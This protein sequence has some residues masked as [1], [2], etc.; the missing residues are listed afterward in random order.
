MK[1]RRIPAKA[2]EDAR[3]FWFHIECWVCS[4]FGLRW[5]Q[6]QVSFH[7]LRNRC[8]NAIF[9]KYL[10]LLPDAD[11]VTIDKDHFVILLI[12][13]LNNNWQSAWI[14]DMKSQGRW[15]IDAK[16]FELNYQ[17]LI[18]VHWCAFDRIYLQ[19]IEK[20]FVQTSS[21]RLASKAFATWAN[22]LILLMK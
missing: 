6:V 10:L 2:D 21:L 5:V 13:F 16:C 8:K 1:S 15:N 14:S 4:T 11:F 17:S 18:M 19:C 7:L 3:L 20:Q 12:K 22:A 9:G